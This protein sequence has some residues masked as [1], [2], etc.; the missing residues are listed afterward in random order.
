MMQRNKDWF[1]P[2]VLG[3]AILVAVGGLGLYFLRKE[4]PEPEAVASS[5]GSFMF[6][7]ARNCASVLRNLVAIQRKM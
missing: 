7:P 4:A 2:W 5:A 6:T 3:A 1:W